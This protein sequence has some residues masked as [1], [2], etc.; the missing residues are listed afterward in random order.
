MPT[1]GTEVFASLRDG[2][3]EA[4]GTVERCEAD[5][6]GLD[7]QTQEL[8]ARRGEAL[9][10]LARHFL[11]EMSRPAIASTFEG[12]RGDLSAILAR[13]EARRKELHSQREAAERDAREHDAQID[14]VTRALNA[15]VAERER[16]EARVAETL[17]GNDDFQQ[18]SKL[19][20][21]A[22][23]QLHR[24]EQRVAE[25]QREAAEKLPAFEN[26]RLFT[27]LYGRG[28]G[29]LDY[30]AKGLTLELD[31]WVAGLIRFG[32]AR[33]G[34]EFLKSTPALVAA[35]VDR[36][37][38]RFNELMQQVEAVQREEADKAGLTAVLKEGEELGRRRDELVAQAEQLRLTSQALQKDLDDLDRRQ[39]SFYAEAIE[40]FRAFLG[41]TKLALIEQ[42]ARRTPEPEDDAIV[43]QI[44]TL[45]DQIAELKSRLADLAERRRDSER[46]RD[47][48]ERVVQRYRQ[49]NF[50]SQRSYF[51]DCFDTHRHL[52][53]YLNGDRNAETLWSS[54]RSAQQF[55]PHWVETT[56]AGVTDVVTSPAGRVILGAVLDAVN[57][58]MQEAAYR[59]VQRRRADINPMPRWPAPSPP[60]YSPRPA[61][62]PPPSSEGS[63]TSGEGF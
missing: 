25:I 42:H 45:N 1:E 16:L 21:Q 19:A 62:P 32:E 13:Q 10:E 17:K 36:R 44:G 33:A 15:K 38:A 55:R 43:A 5:A 47:G 29:T 50:D 59:G 41:E 54:L 24:N 58:T 61:P 9:L 46:V 40:R 28:Y 53:E 11:P 35:E 49:A 34:Y 39:N 27:Y 63:F 56:S 12:I 20:L 3:R 60:T 18:R 8:L 26:S 4:G 37:R 22:E 14:E 6:A 52:D 48:L 2:L 31:R 57:A 7:A 30:Q 23:Q 51:P